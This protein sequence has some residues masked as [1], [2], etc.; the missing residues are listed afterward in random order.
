MSKLEI[1]ESSDQLKHIMNQQTDVHK[2]EK[3][4]ALYLLKSGR[5]EK[6]IDIAD[7]V[8]KGEK[9]VYRWL[10]KYK[11]GG[12]ESLL[13]T[14]KKRGRKRK[15]TPPAEVRLKEAIACRAIDPLN[16]ADIQKWLK[17]EFGIEVSYFVVQEFI[18][19]RLEKESST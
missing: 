12:I 14:S 18:R 8:G 9:S 2:R 4:Q 5:C 15:I 13:S 17:D 6:I 3:I 1:K 19:Y 10:G 16:Y 7:I 11:K